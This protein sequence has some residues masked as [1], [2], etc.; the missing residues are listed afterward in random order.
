M[1][2][3]SC[4]VADIHWIEAKIPKTATRWPQREGRQARPRS[5]LC[6]MEEASP[7]GRCRSSVAEKAWSRR[8]QP[9]IRCMQLFA[10]APGSLLATAL[11]VG[12]R[13]SAC[14]ES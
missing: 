11:V 5:P 9:L 3:H 12:D 6:Y 13:T 7:E 8:D 4:W 1:S 10:T 14:A 2:L